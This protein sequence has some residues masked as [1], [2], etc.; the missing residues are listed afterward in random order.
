MNTTISYVHKN[1]PIEGLMER[2][3]LDYDQ[4]RRVNHGS[5]DIQAYRT[6]MA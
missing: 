5:A 1:T 4:T 2:K 6:T 3:S